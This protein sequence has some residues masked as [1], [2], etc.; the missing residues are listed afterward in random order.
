MN[1]IKENKQKIILATII[2]L[3]LMLLILLFNLFLPMYNYNQGI[4]MFESKNYESSIDF[5]EKSKKYRDS[6]SKCNEVYYE[7]AKVLYESE[8]YEKS[9]EYFLLVDTENKYTWIEQI[10][11]KFLE[12]N[13]YTEAISAF[14][15]IPQMNDERNKWYAYGIA[16]F[17]KQDY[18][19]AITNFKKCDN[20]RNTQEKILEAYYLHGKQLFDGQHYSDAKEKFLNCIS[21]NDSNEQ[22]NKC[23]FKLAEIEYDYGNY[24]SAKECYSQLPAN[25]ELD[26]IKISNRLNSIKIYNSV[27]S[28]D[29]SYDVKKGDY[30]VTQTHN[31]TGIYHYWY[32]EEKG[33]GNLKVDVKM[34]DDGTVNISGKAEG[35]RY[36]SY[37]SIASGVKSGSYYANFSKDISSI[38][39]PSGTLYSDDYIVLKYVGGTTFTLS[40]NEV[41]RSQDVYFRYTYTSNYSFSK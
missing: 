34:N 31:S 27:K 20:I 26:G 37:S 7:Y 18:E 35:T 23:V 16:C 4:K 25:Y 10:G 21:Y 40:Y 11:L 12:E 24:E 14:D 9:L 1:F 6:Q 3:V 36:T 41:D 17:E 5:F 39:L 13:K 38:G 32:N 15:I 30:R 22:I 8:S 29:G 19:N 28:L 2:V 33:Y